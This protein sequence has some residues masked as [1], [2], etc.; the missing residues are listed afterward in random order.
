[1]GK[2]AALPY[3]HRQPFYALI[4]LPVYFSLRLLI[5]FYALS[6]WKLKSANA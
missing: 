6:E 1:M 4:S 3:H 2:A 5:P